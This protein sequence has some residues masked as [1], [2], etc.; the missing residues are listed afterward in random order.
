MRLRCITFVRNELN[1]SKT[2]TETRHITLIIT[3]YSALR[4]RSLIRAVFY[5]QIS[6][7][8]YVL[9]RRNLRIS[10]KGAFDVY[11]SYLE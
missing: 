5:L 3:I 6:I 10:S 11:V 2:C 9:I 1:I 4:K 7:S 8:N